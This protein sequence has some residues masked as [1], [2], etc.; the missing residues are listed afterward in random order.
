MT[1]PRP[2]DREPLQKLCAELS[3]ER[4]TRNARARLHR[5]RQGI[6]K[7]LA[8]RPQNAGR[9]R[10]DSQRP[11]G[12]QHAARNVHELYDLSP[13]QP[14]NRWPVVSRASTERVLTHAVSRVL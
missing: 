8:P 7:N 9:R 4:R 1:E 5:G 6:H 11:Q 14:D 12:G 13:R 2:F 10:A 3:E